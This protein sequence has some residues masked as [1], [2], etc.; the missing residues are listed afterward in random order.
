M[1]LAGLRFFF[2]FRVAS[3]F[4]VDP[5]DRLLPATCGRFNVIRGERAVCSVEQKNTRVSTTRLLNRRTSATTTTRVRRSVSAS[6]LSG[7]HLPVH[8]KRA[9][10]S[11]TRTAV[12]RARY[13][14]SGRGRE[15]ESLR[16]VTKEHRRVVVVVA[17]INAIRRATV[18]QYSR[19][20]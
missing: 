6:S 3:P 20:R 9:R 14:L 1:C 7:A 4:V 15:V 11:N 13:R 5:R 12:S 17:V 16:S 2:L 10:V 8:D 19:A 18:R